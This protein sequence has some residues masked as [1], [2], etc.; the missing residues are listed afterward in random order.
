MNGAEKKKECF[1]SFLLLGEESGG[2][3]RFSFYYYYAF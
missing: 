1:P 2:F 3:L